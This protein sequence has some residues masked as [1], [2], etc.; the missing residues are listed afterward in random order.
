MPLCIVGALFL[1]NHTNGKTEIKNNC[2][3][4]QPVPLN[5]PHG[6]YAINATLY[7]SNDGDTTI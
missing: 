5:E 6:E 4:A 3:E 7:Y 2:Q 1:I